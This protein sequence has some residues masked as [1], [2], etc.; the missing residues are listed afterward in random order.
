MEL[1]CSST[2]RRRP[3]RPVC[4]PHL[5][6]P[7]QVQHAPCAHDTLLD[8]CVCVWPAARQVKQVPCGVLCKS[9]CMFCCL[10]C[11]PGG[12][13]VRS[14]PPVLQGAPP[15]ASGAVPRRIRV[16]DSHRR[17]PLPLVHHGEWQDEQ[18]WTIVVMMGPCSYYQHV[19]SS[20]AGVI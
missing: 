13:P 2:E 5:P 20:Y 18:Q 12:G 7:P 4:S 11:H 9:L 15:R 1:T 19:R 3:A 16:S 6:W 17:G 10:H 14:A 8:E